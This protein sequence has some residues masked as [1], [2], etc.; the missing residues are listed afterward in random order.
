MAQLKSGEI[1]GFLKRPDPRYRT[2]LIYGPDSGLV[3]ERAALLARASV[4]DPEDPFQLVRLEGD[5]LAADPLRLADEANTVGMFGGRRTIRIRAGGKAFQAALEPVLATPPLDSIIIIEAG[6]LAPR[7]PMRALV[8]AAASGLAIPCYADDDRDLPGLVEQALG[9]K[10]LRIEREARDL[11]VTLLG[12]DRLSTRAEVEK[13]ALYCHGQ[14]LV[15]QS[16]V[17]AIM[18]DTGAINLD[19]MIDA[20]FTGDTGTMDTMLRRCL[21]EGMDAGV[22]VGSALRHAMALQKARLA[23]ETGTDYGTVEQAARLHFKRKRAFK[24]QTDI[25]TAASLDKAIAMLA[26]A[27][28]ASRSNGSLGETIA[29]RAFLTLALATRR[30]RA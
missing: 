28:A 27:Q 2:I 3:S 30:G 8:E 20:I 16:D 15:T 29:A 11:F 6:E 9:D 10:G 25:W 13:L 26:D 14:S 21:T 24:R 1:D 7:Q 17:E 19:A 4:D 22:L 18:A 23:L 5:E 12:A